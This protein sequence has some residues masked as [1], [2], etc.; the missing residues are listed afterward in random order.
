M[1]GKNVVEE[2]QE[3]LTASMTID[4]LSVK[5]GSDIINSIRGLTRI[6][7]FVKYK[8]SLNGGLDRNKAITYIILLY[9]KD[10][11]L[12]ERIPIPFA[13][14]QMKA[15]DL[16]GF[17]RHKRTGELDED[18]E[19]RLLM[20][21][22]DELFEMVFAY[23]RF[24]NSNEWREIVT[25]EHELEEFHKLRMRPISETATVKVPGKT[26]ATQQILVSDKDMMMATE[27]KDKLW[28]G[29][30]QRI[31]GLEALYKSFWGDDESALKKSKN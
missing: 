6:D 17:E 26:R 27:K 25:L 16:A 9:S 28:S 11:I 30:Q 15:Y 12:N 10:S 7:E 19:Y 2:T 31:K 24:Q 18:I 14:R 20:L 1:Q 4:I 21:N 5:D 23:M 3:S 13:E 22:D 29:C 8:G